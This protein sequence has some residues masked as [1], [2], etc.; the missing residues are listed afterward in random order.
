M[1]AEAK[2]AQKESRTLRRHVVS[3]NAQLEA[4][5]AELQAQRK[6][7]EQAGTR[8]EKDRKRAKDEK[9]AAQKRHAQEI[10]SHA[11]LHDRKLK[12]QKSLFEEQLATLRKRLANVE[13]QRKQ[14]G[15]DWNKEMQQAIEREQ[16]MRG[17][18]DLLE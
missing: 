1:A 9:E 7:L 10:A 18:V 8:M 13:D 6:E 4:A 17:R 11:A 2:E 15:G 5:E 16:D 14:E 3:L 12:E